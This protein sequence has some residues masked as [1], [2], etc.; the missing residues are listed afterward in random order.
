MPGEREDLD[1]G[2][3]GRTQRFIPVRP[4]FD[5]QRQVGERFD[6]VHHGWFAVQ[7]VDRRE[8]RADARLAAFALD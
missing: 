6:I 2:A 4:L 7:A 5:D 1:P 8:G 3:V